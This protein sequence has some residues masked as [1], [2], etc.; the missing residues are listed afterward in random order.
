MGIATKDLQPLAD[1]IVTAYH[2]LIVVESAASTG[3]RVVLRAMEGP[4][5]MWRGQQS[6]NL[7]GGG[8]GA[9]TATVCVRCLQ[10]RLWDQVA[11]VE[12][13]RAL[14]LVGVIHLAVAAV[15]IAQIF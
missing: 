11:G 8:E 6:E 10:V 2:V 14:R 5:G 3:R 13:A 7:L 12:S 15:D 4:R 1:A 9:G